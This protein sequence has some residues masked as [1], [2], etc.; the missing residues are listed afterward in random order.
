LQFSRQGLSQY[1]NFNQD[2]LY[3]K[4]LFMRGT[5]IL[6]LE[7]KI[8]LVIAGALCVTKDKVKNGAF[9]DKDLGADNLDKA[10]IQMNLENAFDIV[11]PDNH[12]ADKEKISEII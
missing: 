8:R 11:I 3:F 2:N 9:L 10:I 5:N 4:K 1:A 6:F 7:D 12:I